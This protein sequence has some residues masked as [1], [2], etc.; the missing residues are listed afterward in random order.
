MKVNV[1]AL[2][3]VVDFDDGAMIVLNVGQSGKLTEEKA[4]TLAASG[5]IKIVAQKKKPS[6]KEP[7]L[8]G[9]AAMNAPVLQDLAIQRGV[10]PE[11]GSGLEGSVLK[12]DIINALEADDNKIDYSTMDEA[13]LIQ[14]ATESGVMPETGTGED[15]AVTQA[16][17]VAALEQPDQESAPV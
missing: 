9:Y 6:E 13:E 15:G 14:L 1:K 8:T 2:A 16:D 5:K 3:S 7:V 12:A 17:L 11:S 10:M 4:L